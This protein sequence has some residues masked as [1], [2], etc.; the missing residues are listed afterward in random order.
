MRPKIGC[1][2]ETVCSN[3]PRLGNEV[4]Y[5]LLLAKDLNLLTA[6]EHKDLEA[7]VLEI[8]RMLASLVQSL[9][10]TVLASSQ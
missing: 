2:D 6:D 8:E 9:K 1:R 5:H 3:R 4:E 7:K 10:V